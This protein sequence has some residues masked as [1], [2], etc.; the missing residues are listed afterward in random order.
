MMTNVVIGGLQEHQIIITDGICST[1]VAGCGTGGGN[2]PLVV[3]KEDDLKTD[4][5]LSLNKDHDDG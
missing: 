2:T 1:I 5:N 4:D 3:E